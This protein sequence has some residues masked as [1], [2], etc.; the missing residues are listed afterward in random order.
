MP[1]PHHREKLAAPRCPKFKAVVQAAPVAFDL[2]RTLEKVD[3][4][5]TKAARE[6]NLHDTR[7]TRIRMASSSNRR[8]VQA[9]SL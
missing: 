1:N 3:V 8:P 9:S 4:L 7:M 2:E 6:A 5:A